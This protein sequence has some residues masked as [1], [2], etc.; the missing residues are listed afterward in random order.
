MSQDPFSVLSQV[1]TLRVSSQAAISILK[2]RA[3]CRSRES[4]RYQERQK[5]AGSH[6][7]KTDHWAKDGQPGTPEITIQKNHLHLSIVGGRGTLERLFLLHS[8]SQKRSEEQAADRIPK[9]A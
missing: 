7:F 1:R 9:E 8:V 6:I 5:Y 2:K 3:P 4:Q